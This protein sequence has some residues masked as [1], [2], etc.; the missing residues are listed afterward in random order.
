MAD[1]ELYVR[2]QSVVTRTIGGETLIVPVRGGV[3]DLASIYSLNEIGGFIWERLAQ[4]TTAE[5]IAGSIVGS[6]ET[7]SEKA[8]Q[9][10]ERFLRE[11]KAANLVEL[12]SVVIF[13]QQVMQTMQTGT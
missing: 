9:D 10:V 13:P 2:S 11:M 6:Y 4:A 7:T 1:A 3:G 12:R 5:E 8:Q